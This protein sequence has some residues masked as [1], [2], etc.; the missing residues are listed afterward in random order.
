MN[1]AKGL[2]RNRRLRQTPED[3]NAWAPGGWSSG[4]SP[5]KKIALAR[6]VS[7]QRGVAIPAISAGNNR[8]NDDD[9]DNDDA[10]RTSSTAG[11]TIDNKVCN[12]STGSTRKGNIRN[13][14]DRTR[15]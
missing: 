9:C 5:L 11:S 7:S 12:T 14:P 1:R 2:D 10:L 13:S 4:E 3:R 8:G 15:Y 6:N